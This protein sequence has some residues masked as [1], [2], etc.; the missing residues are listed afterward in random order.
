VPLALV[1]SPLLLPLLLLLLLESSPGRAGAGVVGKG[2]SAAAEDGLVVE[3]GES[4]GAAAGVA[5]FA[6]APGNGNCSAADGFF[7]G[8]GHGV[9]G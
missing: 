8:C 7:A 6:A 9:D 1:L 5:G 4:G 2:C 3:P